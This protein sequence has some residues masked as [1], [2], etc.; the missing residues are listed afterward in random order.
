MRLTTKIVLGIIA[1]IFL[2]SII[3]IICLSIN[4]G[5]SSIDE[6]AMTEN[7]KMTSIDISTHKFI[8]LDMEHNDNNVFF[9]GTLDFH[10][11][12]DENEKEKWPFENAGEK[13]K[14]IVTE[15]LKP[16][17]RQVLAGD[18]LKLFLKPFDKMMSKKR[19]ARM[20]YV[21]SKIKM[22]L[23]H[24]GDINLKNNISF[25]SVNIND[26]N[27]N[28]MNLSSPGEIRLQNC[29]VDTINPSIRKNDESFFLS[30]HLSIN[31]SK[32]DILN[33]KFVGNSELNLNDSKI[34][35]GNF[36]GYTNKKLTIPANTFKKINH[37]KE[38]GEKSLELEIFSD[39][40]QFIFP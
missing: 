18:T 16:N 40:V 37:I 5:R 34:E 2:I 23:F 39:T 22:I 13:N 14:L 3:T 15:E 17:I 10:P 11:L 19:N 33:F 21:E 1:A 25:I 29:T 8:T 26:I 6:E 27:T 30:R 24:E 28:S 12:L 31:N 9:S 35:T 7:T 38:A 4:N 36:Y 20:Y 32:I